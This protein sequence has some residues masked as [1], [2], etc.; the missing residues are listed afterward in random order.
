MIYVQDIKKTYGKVQALKGVSLEVKKGELFGL[1]GPDGAGKTTLMR[2]LMSLLLPDSGQATMNGY[3]VVKE[4]KQIR[5]QTGYMPG[6]FSLYPD[7]TVEENLD[8]FAT[9]FGTSISENYDLIKD[10]YV[11]IEPF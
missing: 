11:Q 6:R 5:M 1:I 4:Y 3:D 8:F 10:I 7:L 9:V 2:I